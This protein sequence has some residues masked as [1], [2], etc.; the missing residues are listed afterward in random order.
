M[1]LQQ[2]GIPDN[3]SYLVLGM[4]ILFGLLGGWIASLL[5]RARNLRRDLEIL[6]RTQSDR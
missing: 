3:V 2:A 4:V 5:W 6:R 1:F